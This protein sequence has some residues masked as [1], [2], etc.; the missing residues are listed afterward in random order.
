MVSPRTPPT[1][2]FQTDADATM[3]AE[4]SVY[5]YLA[6]RKAGVKAEMHVFQNGPH[7]VMD[8][9]ALAAWPTLLANWLRV[10]GFV[11]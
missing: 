4:N 2:I 5:Y 10:N 8:D 6:L 11:K 1:F 9:P 7:G 3:P